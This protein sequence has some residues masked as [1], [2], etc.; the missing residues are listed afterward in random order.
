MRYNCGVS[1]NLPLHSFVQCQ[2]DF[3]KMAKQRSM[4]GFMDFKDVPMQ[5]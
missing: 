3:R 2:W 4:E 5:N 1:Q